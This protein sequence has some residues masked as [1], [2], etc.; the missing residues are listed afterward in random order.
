MTFGFRAMF[1]VILLMGLLYFPAWH[2]QFVYDDLWLV[3]RNP[4]IRSIHL[5]SFFAHPETVAVAGSGLASDI[6]RPLLTL[7]FACDFHAWKLATWPYHMENLF[8]HGIN[9]FLLW[10]LMRKI[11][12]RN[13]AA[14]F[15]ASVFLLH[16]VQ[17]QSVAWIAERSNVLSGAGFLTALA[18]LLWPEEKPFLKTFAGWATYAAALFVKE[19]VIVLPVVWFLLESLQWRKS[20]DKSSRRADLRNAGG[21]LFISGGYLIV[22]QKLLHHLS[23]M[24]ESPRILWADAT[25]GLMAFPVYLGKM[26][27]PLALRVS[28]QYP[29]VTTSKLVWAIG[30]SAVYGGTMIWSWQRWP[31][32]GRSLAWI[33]VGLAPVLQIVPIRAFVAERF[34]YFPM[35][36]FA[37]LAG[38]G[39]EKYARRRWLL[40]F[41]LVML[42]GLTVAA[43][44]PWR[45]ETRLWRNAVRQE[46]TNAFAQVCYAESLSDYVE[47]AEH[48]KA[49]L[50][51]TPSPDLRFSAMNNL[52]WINLQAHH[53]QEALLWSSRALQEKPDD[54][55]ALYNQCAAYLELEK[56]S[57][58]RKVYQRL[59]VLTPESTE[60]LQNL[61][62]RLSRK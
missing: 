26:L 59:K 36:G 13:D 54:V 56:L 32:V 28:Y 4:A 60:M 17:V 22:R 25:L 58:A 21:L 30:I 7:S 2:G 39:F 62:Q 33:L 11:L 40:R 15:G 55:H 19:S 48:Y 52:A 61:S 8:W 51:N 57:Q 46:P 50:R 42:G 38:W 24:P 34:L 16:P 49:A 23:Q 10:F 20:A 29:M 1:F 47:A 9:G 18:C 27:L 53:P 35:M 43:A 31:L 41:W 37:L 14:L 6:Y 3:V 45:D 44:F 12:T 5:F